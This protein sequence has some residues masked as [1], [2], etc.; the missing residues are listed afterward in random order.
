MLR[1]C[2]EKEE[3]GL[4]GG[5]MGGWVGGWTVPPPD[6]F[7]TLKFEKILFFVPA[8]V[9]HLRPAFGGDVVFGG[10]AEVDVES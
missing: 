2:V 9:G 4:V 5:L 3:R 8:A 10:I 6:E 1:G 7:S